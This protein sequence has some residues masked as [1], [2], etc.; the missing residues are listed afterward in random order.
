MQKELSEDE[1]GLIE[2][3]RKATDKDREAIRWAAEVAARVQN[4]KCERRVD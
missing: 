4:R 1:Q 2:N 3:Y